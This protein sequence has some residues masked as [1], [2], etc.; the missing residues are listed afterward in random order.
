MV[1]DFKEEQWGGC[2]LSILALGLDRYSEKDLDW[3]AAQAKVR[4]CQA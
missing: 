2:D 4:P 3:M 1:Y